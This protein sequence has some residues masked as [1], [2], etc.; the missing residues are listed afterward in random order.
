MFIWFLFGL[1]DL[2]DVF[3]IGFKGFVMF[4]HICLKASCICFHKLFLCFL[5]S[6]VG[7]SILFC[8]HF[9]SLLTFITVLRFLLSTSYFCLLNTLSVLCTYFIVTLLHCFYQIQLS[10]FPKVLFFLAFLFRFQNSFLI[11]KGIA[12]QIFFAIK[13]LFGID[14]SHFLKSLSYFC[15]C[16]LE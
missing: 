15:V 13:Y 3:F 14:F 4:V 5:F 7:L 6:H 11:G 12:Q 9:M 8:I 2:V 16:L 10:F 1:Y